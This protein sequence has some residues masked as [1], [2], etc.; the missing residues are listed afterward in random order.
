M[1]CCLLFGDSERRWRL[2]FLRN[3]EVRKLLAAINNN[4]STTLFALHMSTRTGLPGGWGFGFLGE[5]HNAYNVLFLEKYGR[6]DQYSGLESGESLRKILLV[7]F[8][9][10]KI[11]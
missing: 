10:R 3:I 8:T 2:G 9:Q 1:E 11:E 7:S 5:T 4:S 6:E